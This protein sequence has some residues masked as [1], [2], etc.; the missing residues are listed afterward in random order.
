MLLHYW[1]LQPD[2]WWLALLDAIPLGFG[3]AVDYG[4]FSYIGM[5]SVDPS[6]Q[7]RGIGEALMKQIL[8]WGEE[9]ACPTML[10]E[11]NQKAVSLYE[12]LGFIEEDTTLYLRLNTPIEGLKPPSDVAILQTEDTS[13]LVHFDAFYFGAQREKIFTS[14]LA[15]PERAFVTR[16]EAGN[17]T[18]YI[19]A[20][21]G[22][23]GPWVASTVEDAEKLLLRALVLPFSGGPTN[24]IPATNKDGQELLKQYGFSEL[25]QA[26]VLCVVAFLPS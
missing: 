20:Q 12:R 16:N 6:V 21:P 25:A 4:L 13:E 5:L 9:R 8:T 14:H 1:S 10:L 19:F 3:G 15:D 26:A 11:T 22:N 7:R 23:I 2:G 18:G 24:T 17:I